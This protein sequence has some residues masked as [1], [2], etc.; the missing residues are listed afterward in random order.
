MISLGIFPPD[1][2][3][4]RGGVE[5]VDEEV[6]RDEGVKLCGVDTPE[7]FLPVLF[8]DRCVCSFDV[9][10]GTTKPASIN[11]SDRF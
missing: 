4:V 11:R 8:S 6:V 9:T 5:V 1:L 2:D 3:G 10:P 7:I